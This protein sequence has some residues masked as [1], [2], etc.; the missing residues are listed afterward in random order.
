MFK[1]LRPAVILCLVIQPFVVSASTRDI[2]IPPEQEPWKN[3]V[4]EGKEYL[5]CP[6]F[7]N[8]TTAESSFVCA[9]PGR[10]NL[11]I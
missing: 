11:E 1:S 6:F 8:Q 9:W 10:L 7:F 4:L 2:Y 3:W 5:D